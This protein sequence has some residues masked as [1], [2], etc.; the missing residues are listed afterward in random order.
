MRLKW[1]AIITR[2]CGG[3][4]QNDRLFKLS[5]SH[6]DCR[7]TAADASSQEPVHQFVRYGEATLNIGVVGVVTSQIK[8][9]AIITILPGQ[10]HQLRGATLKNP[11]WPPFQLIMEEG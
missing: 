8:R 7:S 3:G 9:T 4:S 1:V 11:I 2:P 5:V 10:A 6:N